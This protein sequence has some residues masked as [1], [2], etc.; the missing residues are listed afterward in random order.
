[1]IG[2]D[3]DFDAHPGAQ[4]GQVLLVRVD[5][6]SQWDALH[7][8]YPVT[9]G[10]LRGQERELLRCRWTDALNDT[11]PYRVRVSVDRQ[12]WP[13]RTYVNSVSFGVAST[14]T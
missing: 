2:I 10:V 6:H 1:V 13:D 9:A 4:Q 8:F 7:D 12:D 14:Q 11:V 3:I 5:A